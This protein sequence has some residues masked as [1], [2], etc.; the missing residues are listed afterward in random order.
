MVVVAVRVAVG[1]AV[2]VAVV[3]AWAMADGGRVRGLSC[4][5]FLRIACMLCVQYSPTLTLIGSMKLTLED[6]E[7]TAQYI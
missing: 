4:D 6:F 2:R 5:I 7:R 3:I 1:V